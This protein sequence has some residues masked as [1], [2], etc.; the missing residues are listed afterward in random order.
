MKKLVKLL[1]LVVVGWKTEAQA[2][3]YGGNLNMNVAAVFKGRFDASGEI[4][5]SSGLALD[6]DGI[7]FWTHN[8]QGNPTTKVYNFLPNTGNTNV[9]V[10][11]T[12]NVNAVNLDWED[13]A[14]DTMGNLYLAQTG[15][16]CNANATPDCPTKFVFKIHK[17]AFS[18]LTNGSTVTPETFY[19]KYPLS[20]YALNNCMSNDTVFANTEAVIW[21]NNS[22]YVFTK[23]IFSKKTNNCGG[24]VGGN[25]HLF[26]V[27][28]TAGSTEAN[29]IVAQYL[30]ALTTKINSTEDAGLYQVTGAA[31]NT[32][33]TKIALSTYGRLWILEGFTGDNFFSG[34]KTYYNFVDNNN[35]SQIRGYEGIEFAADNATLFLSV[36]GVNGRVVSINPAEMNIAL[37]ALASTTI[38]QGLNFSVPFLATGT[39]NAGNTFEVQ[40][41]ASSN[42]TTYTVI[43][44]GTGS[45]VTATVPTGVTGNRIRVVANNP[46]SI[47]NPLTEITIIKTTENITGT[48]T[49][50]NYRAVNSITSTAQIASG[51]TVVM[52]AGQSVT[53]N[54]GF[55]ANAGSV[56]KAE[57]LGC[58]NGN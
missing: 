10:S 2:Q 53:L 9:T 41:S 33:G 29:P 38:C 4:T 26:K 43:G 12:V 39:I 27:P 40:L 51:N 1:L 42:F 58:S 25:T 34:T 18:S 17:M 14:K 24:W 54:T 3:V 30:G 20:G 13:L 55:G 22:I 31:I 19:F 16:N 48:I 35:Q 52:Q 57:I 56:F 37:N 50:N 49:T 44:S 28:L 23:D 36:D 45:P 15:K 46:M 32:S 6:P 21:F 11:K 5:Q 8:D 7:S 47:S